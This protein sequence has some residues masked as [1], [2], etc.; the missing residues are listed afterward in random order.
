MFY[1]SQSRSGWGSGGNL[2]TARQLMAGF[3][4]QT[5]AVGA[6]GDTSPGPQANV[7]HYDG[8]SWTNATAVPAATGGAGATGT[9]TAGLLVG[10]TPPTTE[11]YEYDG[12]S[13]TATPDISPGKIYSRM[14][15]TQTDAIIFGGQSGPSNP[16][17]HNNQQNYNGTSW[18]TGASL[19]TARS[20]LGG[21]GSTSNSALAYTGEIVPG[22]QSN[23]T[24]SFD[25]SSW[26]TIPATVATARERV[27]SAG[28]SNSSALLFGGNTPPTVSITEEFT[29][30]LSA[31]TAGAWAAGAS[32][33]LAT[34]G[35]GG[36]GT[37]TAGLL[38]GGYQPSS[39]S[40][41]ETETYNGTSFT[42]V[43]DLST[44]RRYLAGFGTQT[45]AV[46]AGG[47]TPP[48]RVTAVEEW[49]GSVSVLD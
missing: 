11:S 13:W 22:S 14:A 35:R 33:N 40:R 48:G 18:T 5:A 12:S 34:Y 45:A 26:T 47:N 28:A 31:T 46:A 39:Q 30:S 27:G 8:S 42:E 44:G 6:G 10:G 43:A 36:C 7:E 20:K 9:Q 2:N 19:N 32:M 49:N 41:T 29:V 25:G 37:T 24:E 15:G 1:V 38:F 21:S 17:I 16:T 4:T 23:V 3:G